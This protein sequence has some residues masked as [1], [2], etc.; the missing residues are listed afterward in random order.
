MDHVGFPKSVLGP[1][2]FHLSINC[3]A[4]PAPGPVLSPGDGVM[5]LRAGLC[6]RELATSEASQGASCLRFVWV[7]FFGKIFIFFY[8]S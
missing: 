3:E 7:Y 5:I 8:Y 4:Y 6:P 2:F 1:V